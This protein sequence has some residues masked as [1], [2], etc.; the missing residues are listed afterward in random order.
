MMIL[1]FKKVNLA[2]FQHYNLQTRL[3]VVMFKNNNL[4]AVV[5]R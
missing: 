2:T 1:F 5:E 3:K 4:S